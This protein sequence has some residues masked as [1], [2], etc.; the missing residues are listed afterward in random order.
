MN[1]SVAGLTVRMGQDILYVTAKISSQPFARDQAA[2][3]RSIDTENTEEQLCCCIRLQSV[4][5]V[6][7]ILLLFCY[8]SVSTY[9]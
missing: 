6:S 5:Y 8:W 3:A 1:A 7:R 9:K 2:G 4:L